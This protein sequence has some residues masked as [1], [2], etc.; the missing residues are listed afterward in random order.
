MIFPFGLK[1]KP[2]PHYFKQGVVKFSMNE[3]V[4]NYKITHITKTIK[5]PLIKGQVKS[6]EHLDRLLSIKSLN[7]IPLIE[8]VN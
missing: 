4:M 8:V 1:A 2:L 3:G 7:E 5:A 6:K